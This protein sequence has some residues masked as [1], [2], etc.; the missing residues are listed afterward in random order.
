MCHAAPPRPSYGQRRGHRR[1]LAS[2][3]ARRRA[4]GPTPRRSG[5]R[6][7]PLAVSPRHRLRETARRS[8]P[9]ARDRTAPPRP[10]SLARRR[11]APRVP[12]QPPLQ[13]LM[14]SVRRKGIDGNG[15]RGQLPP[16]PCDGEQ[17]RA[18]RGCQRLWL[19]SHE[20]PHAQPG[21]QTGDNRQGH[22]NGGNPLP[23]RTRKRAPPPATGVEAL[24]RCTGAR[25]RGSAVR[26]RSPAPLLSWRKRV[27]GGSP[28]APEGR[29]TP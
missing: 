3:R 24:L 2:P 26:V 28:R 7:T 17:H 16:A 25:N 12:G 1:P 5:H 4:C 13:Q 20:A 10:S 11:D 18:Q 19:R 29:L 27:N 14:P 6:E 21:H 9:V 23:T 8:S 15:I 22:P